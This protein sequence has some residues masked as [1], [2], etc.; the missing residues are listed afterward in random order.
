MKKP[1]KAAIA[2]ALGISAPAFSKYVRR[3]CPVYSVE[4][5]LAWQRQH[6]D[7]SQRMLRDAERGTAPA[8]S[9]PPASDEP[10]DLPH[11]ADRDEVLRILDALIVATRDGAELRREHL[12]MVERLGALAARDR[13]LELPLR[14]VLQ[15]TPF[16]LGSEL[17]LPVIVRCRLIGPEALAALRAATAEAADDD[18]LSPEDARAA[19]LALWDLVTG[20]RVLRL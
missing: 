3:G 19:D 10:A 5:A 17:R 2:Q 6:V 1:T 11:P 7:P 8:S 9:R 20:R 4:A 13:R 16:D 15:R 12:P 18:R 14:A